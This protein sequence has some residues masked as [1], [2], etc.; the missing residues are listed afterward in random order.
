IVTAPVI[1]AVEET[2][3]ET[4][5]S[6]INGNIGGTTAS[7]V[8]NDTLNGIAV[9]I[10]T[11]P[12]QVKLTGLS[13]PSGLTLNADGTVTVA[14]ST[15]AGNY[16]LEYSICEINNPANCDTAISKIVVTTG[17]LQANID[18]I[19][20]VVGINQPTA[21]VNVFANDTNDGLPVIA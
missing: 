10:G 16:D 21:L 12:G 2:V 18:I 9:V 13:V 7:L 5:S 8:S 19:G 14:P 6:I 1:D 4:T 20:S 3:E 17:V 15:P 11:Q